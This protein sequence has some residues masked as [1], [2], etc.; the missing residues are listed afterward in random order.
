M[1]RAAITAKAFD[2]NNIP[3]FIGVDSYISLSLASRSFQ[4][5]TPV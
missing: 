3:V 5:K 1:A 2:A 4:T